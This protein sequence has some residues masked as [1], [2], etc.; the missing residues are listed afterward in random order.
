MLWIG[1]LIA[2]LL[3]FI[4]VLRFTQPR[5]KCPKCGSY[6]VGLTRKDPQG[7]RTFDYHTGGAGGGYTTVQL[8]YEVTYCCNQCQ[9]TWRKMIT[10]SR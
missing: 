6:Q 4:I 5:P 8:V 10:E 9:A 1:S 7:M 3:I 2:F